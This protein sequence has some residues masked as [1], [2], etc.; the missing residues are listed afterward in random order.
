MSIEVANPYG[1]SW[2]V[3]FSRDKDEP[4]VE[5]SCGGPCGEIMTMWDLHC[6]PDAEALAHK[7]AKR[8]RFMPDAY[9]NVVSHFTIVSDSPCIRACGC[10]ETTDSCWDFG[11]NCLYEKWRAEDDEAAV[12][13]WKA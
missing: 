7:F 2:R 3:Y 5:C 9:E 1:E 10:H 6:W 13:R 4:T 11:E 12:P 8:M